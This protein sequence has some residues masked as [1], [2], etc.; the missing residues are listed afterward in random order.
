MSGDYSLVSGSAEHSV[1]YSSSQEAS[2]SVISSFEFSYSIKQKYKESLK[3]ITEWQTYDTSPTTIG[4]HNWASGLSENI[5]NRLRGSNRICKQGDVH[6]RTRQISDSSLVRDCAK[7]IHT[8]G[9]V[10]SL[11]R[12]AGVPPQT[13]LSITTDEF[14]TEFSDGTSTTGGDLRSNIEA[15][16]NASKKA[17][18]SW[19]SN[20]Q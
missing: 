8:C 4:N 1:S 13:S 15:A 11:R 5:Q 18:N 17:A 19:W 16:E 14:K 12:E 7:F 20:Q 3:Y 10:S 2:R 9:D 6:L